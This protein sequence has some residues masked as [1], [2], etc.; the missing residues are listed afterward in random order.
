MSR[1]REEDELLGWAFDVASRRGVLAWHPLPA[2]IRAGRI[3]TA[4]QG[5]TAGF[6]DAVFAGR[7]GVLFREFKATAGRVSAD[8]QKWID[9]LTEAGADVAVWYPA[10]RLTG[11]ID[12]E[13]RA[14][15]RPRRQQPAAGRD[16]VANDLD[17]FR[18]ALEAIREADPGSPGA[19]IATAALL[20]HTAKEASRG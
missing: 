8:Q 2:S 11:R 20:R 9:R 4:A 5:D 14:I 13:L 17:A 19:R 18:A 7:G 15:A 12:A 3:I 10:D 16:Q 1:N 6:P